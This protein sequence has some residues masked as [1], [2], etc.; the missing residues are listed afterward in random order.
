LEANRVH[1]RRITV[2]GSFALSSLVLLEP[3]AFQ[4]SACLQDEFCERSFMK[5]PLSFIFPVISFCLLLNPLLPSKATGEALERGGGVIGDAGS[6]VQL[7]TGATVPADFFY[8]RQAVPGNYRQVKPA[9]FPGLQ[10]Q[11]DALLKYLCV[12]WCPSPRSLEKEFEL[13]LTDQ[14]SGRDSFPVDKDHTAINATFS[15]V[16]APSPDHRLPRL[17]IEIQPRLFSS[18]SPR[19]QAIQLL[20]EVMHHNTRYGHAVISPLLKGLGLVFDLMDRQAQ[21]DRS[22]LTAAETDVF[23]QMW[24]SLA[25][26]ETDTKSYRFAPNGGGIVECNHAGS[27]K[28][29]E[30]FLAKNFVSANS[31]VELKFAYG[32]YW[33]IEDRNYGPVQGNEFFDVVNLALELSPDKRPCVNNRFQHVSGEKDMS[34]AY[35][36]TQRTIRC[37]GSNNQLKDVSLDTGGLTIAGDDNQLSQVEIHWYGSLDVNVS[38]L[39]HRN[40]IRNS[41]LCLGKLGD[42]AV[43]TNSH[44]HGLLKFRSDRPDR[45]IIKNSY[46]NSQGFEIAVDSRVPELAISNL[47]VYTTAQDLVIEP[48]APVLEFSPLGKGQYFYFKEASL[49]SWPFY[50]R[51]TVTI[52]NV[53]A[54]EKQYADHLFTQN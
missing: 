18:L 53:E 26:L 20:H 47:R 49:S 39:G 44:V 27:E 11:Y 36:A 21:G 30:D 22:A 50:A 5:T 10:A 29:C 25:T 37:Q 17:I 19:G 51:G 38:T 54:F 40:R 9:D 34:G 41:F 16:V 35:Y 7:P 6:V 23:T 45:V 42:N 52:R 14:L 1:L 43:I 2:L 13:R 46:I 15:Y 12:L 24:T 28:R 8:E 33:S 48:E 32:S 4:K 3:D 31:R